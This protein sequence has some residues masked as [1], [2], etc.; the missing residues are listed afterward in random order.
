MHLIACR[1][2][3]LV[4]ILV[5]SLYSAC[6]SATPLFPVGNVPETRPIYA[7]FSGTFSYDAGTGVLRAV[8]DQAVSTGIVLGNERVYGTGTLSFEAV[9]DE[10][11]AVKCGSAEWVGNITPGAIPDDPIL[12]RG[13]ITDVAIFDASPFTGFP[14]IDPMLQMVIT[15][16]EPDPALG[17]VSKVGFQHLVPDLSKPPGVTM[18]SFL[19]NPFKFS[20][21]LPPSSFG[22]LFKALQPVIVLLLI[23]ILAVL[24]IGRRSRESY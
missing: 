23:I 19:Q 4:V 10:S 14:S 5:Q 9:I 12:L 18:E 15:V 17:L 13:T 20:F 24:V 16:D 21:G 22:D 2:I 3:S 7:F 11:G 8:S 1:L 6:T